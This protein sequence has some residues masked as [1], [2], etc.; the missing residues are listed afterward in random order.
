[1]F[2]GKNNKLL[3]SGLFYEFNDSKPETVL[4]TLDAQDRDLTDNPRYGKIVK[5]IKSAYLEMMDVAEFDFA[6]KYFYDYRHWRMIKESAWFKDSYAML[7]EELEA[8][9]ASIAVSKMMEQVNAGAAG[10]QT[11]AYLANKGYLEKDKVGRPNKKAVEKQAKEEVARKTKEQQE[12]DKLIEH[13]PKLSK[14][15]N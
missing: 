2:K 6:N 13:N 1:M 4:Y 15:V 14:L 10:H 12:L 7:R 11:L 9:L 8:K 5:S 3:T